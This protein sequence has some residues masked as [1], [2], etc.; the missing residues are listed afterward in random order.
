MLRII[1]L[2]AGLVAALPAHA[3]SSDDLQDIAEAAVADAVVQAKALFEAGRYADAVE[4]LLVA[5][6][7]APS[8]AEIQ[9]LLGFAN[10]KAGNF[11][12][13]RLRYDRALTLDP[14]HRGALEYRGELF[15]ETGDP[16]AARADLAT[17][18]RICGTGCEEYRELA[19]K[20]AA[21]G[22]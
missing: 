13:A 11:A 19:E 20:I 21:A 2:L 4:M 16:E 10:R 18:E 1:L 17:L 9:N 14:E 6:K 15:L 7:S 22:S 5:E 3:V 12:E 8:S